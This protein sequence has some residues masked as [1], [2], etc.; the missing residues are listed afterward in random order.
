MSHYTQMKILSTDT[1]M[2][3]SE[4]E[5]DQDNLPEADFSSSNPGLGPSCVDGAI[6][7]PST[8]NW[9]PTEDPEC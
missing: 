6:S 8:K 1:I 9:R 2:S 4:D 3:S 7:G 5:E